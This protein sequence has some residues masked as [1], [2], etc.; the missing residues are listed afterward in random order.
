MSGDRLNGCVDARLI[1]GT[2]IEYSVVGANNREA[3]H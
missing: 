3:V 1:G 2:L